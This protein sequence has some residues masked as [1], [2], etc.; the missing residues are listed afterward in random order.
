MPCS[1]SKRH[2]LSRD[3]VEREYGISRRWL[4]LAALAGNGPP[5]VRLTPRLVRYRRDDLDDWVASKT[6]AS[7][8]DGG[9]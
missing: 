7:T 2:L 9:V 5:M 1:G 4:E 6:V 3:D 8:S